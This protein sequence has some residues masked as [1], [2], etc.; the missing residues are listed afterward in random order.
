MALTTAQVTKIYKIFGLPQANEAL[1][2]TDWFS[3]P[4]PATATMDLSAIK[5]KLD[6]IL[7]ALSATQET[8]VAALVVAWDAVGDYDELRVTR[9]GTSEG[10]LVDREKRRENIR[11]TLGALIGFVAPTGGFTRGAGGGG[12]RIIR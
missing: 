7:A 4:G 2:V 1:V 8:E 10:V 11:R 5:A 3:I 6:A 9:D 12:G